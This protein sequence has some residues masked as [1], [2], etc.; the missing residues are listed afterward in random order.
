MLAAID[1]LTGQKGAVVDQVRGL[2]GLVA[3]RPDHVAL[4]AVGAVGGDAS[5]LAVVGEVDRVLDEVLV[6]DAGDAGVR[7]DPWGRRC[8]FRLVNAA[9]VGVRPSSVGGRHGP[10]RDR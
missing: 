3:G 10:F 9:E 8:G 4:G 5:A 6:V 1:E 2:E 7:A